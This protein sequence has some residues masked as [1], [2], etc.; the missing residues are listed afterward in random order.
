VGAQPLYDLGATWTPS[1]ADVDAGAGAGA[2]VGAVTLVSTATSRR[3]G[4]RVFALV[5]FNDTNA[6]IVAHNASAQVTG[7]VNDTGTHGM[8]FRVNGA[9]LYSRGAVLFPL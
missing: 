8:F 6:T 4:F 2:G 9:A 5:T 1:P 3:M 7:Q